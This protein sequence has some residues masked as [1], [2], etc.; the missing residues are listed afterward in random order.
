MH[1]HATAAGTPTRRIVLRS[2]GLSIAKLPPPLL[3]NVNPHRF[4]DRAAIPTVRPGDL[5]LNPFNGATQFY[6]N[7]AGSR[8]SI[9]NENAK[10][11]SGLRKNA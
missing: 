3:C 5:L 11:P 9:D 1:T 7:R 8:Q 10:I 6:A 4:D 2:T